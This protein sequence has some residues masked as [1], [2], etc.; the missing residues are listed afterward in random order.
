MGLLILATER[1]TDA[2]DQQAQADKQANR[3]YEEWRL[4]RLLGDRRLHPLFADHR[5]PTER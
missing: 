3:S 4:C 1:Q 5:S 2:D